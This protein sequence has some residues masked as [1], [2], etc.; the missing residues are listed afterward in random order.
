MRVR[1]VYLAGLG[2]YLPASV[3]TV[4]AVARG[5]YDA[6]ACER[7][8]WT[9][10]AVAGEVSAPDMA[11]FAARRA[12][13]RAGHAPSEVDLVLHA[14]FFHQGPDGWSPHNYVQRHTVG[15]HAPAFEVRQACN[16]MLSGLE[17]ACAYLT[18]TGGT[19]ALVTGAENFGVALVD[20]W[21]YLA[22]ATTN[23]GSILGD[24]GTA[25]VLSRRAGFARLRAIGTTTL[26]EYEEMYRGDTPV[27]PPPCT[28]GEPMRI[29]ARVAE[30]A[31]R[32]PARFA[33]LRDE[34]GAA[35]SDL[36]ARTLAEAG[37]TPAAITRVTHVFTGGIAYL[38]GLLTPLG[39]AP[40]RG[41]LDYGRGVGH[42]GVNDHVAGLTHLVE[43][44]AV[45]A[46][47]HVLMMGNGGG[48]ALSCAVVEI[49][50]DVNW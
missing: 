4:D 31:Q 22:G 27:F 20:R 24:A 45:R 35:R 23:R 6:D 9:G 41:L 30:F 5:D 42:L 14:S 48:I 17:L 15:G 19:A 47:D 38:R 33:A 43:T 34:L 36:A 8:G 12:L 37:V 18:A 50:D 26:P 46:G 40:E 3:S 32:H 21:R 16:G 39:I 13:D 25:V 49:L 44:G 10:A 7:D 2:A 11:V 29:G 1:D 28:V